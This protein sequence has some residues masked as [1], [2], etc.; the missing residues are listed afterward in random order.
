M[1]TEIGIKEKDRKSVKV[2]LTTILSDEMVLLVKT[3]NF[4]WNVTGSNFNEL[5]SFFQ[6]QYSLLETAVDEIA[7][8]IRM[9]GFYSIGSMDEFLKSA[10]LKGNKQ[11]KESDK[12]LAELLSDYETSI[13]YL[14]IV[15]ADCVQKYND[16]GTN[17]FLIGLMQVHEK[18]AWMIR[19]YFK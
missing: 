6:Q 1:K 18:S 13:K 12:M 16:T 5:H 10:T 19:S 17:D 4:H 7:E 3:K 8:R 2:L 14:R 9:L 11:V 15:S